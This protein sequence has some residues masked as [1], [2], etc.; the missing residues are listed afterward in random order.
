[1]TIEPQNNNLNYL[2]D[3]AF[4]NINILFILFFSRNNNA[5]NRHTFSDHYVSEK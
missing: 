5:H 2:I 1:M 4:T 3:P